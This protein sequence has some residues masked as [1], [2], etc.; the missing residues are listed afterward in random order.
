MT[1]GDG[2]RQV[3]AITFTFLM[4]TSVIAPVGGAA[5][6]QSAGNDAIATAGNDAPTPATGGPANNAT[7][8]PDTRDPQTTEVWSV[9]AGSPK[10]IHDS[11]YAFSIEE[12]I[13]IDQKD[14]PTVDEGSIPPI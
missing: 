14:I 10:P 3:T 2:W 7:G 12:L 1:G 4:I 11:R 6:S 5:M 9:M 13:T 8:P